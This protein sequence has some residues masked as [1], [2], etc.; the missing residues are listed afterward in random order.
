E[1]SMF[2]T[3]PVYLA[4]IESDP[5]RIR[6]VTARFLLTSRALDTWIARRLA[7]LRTPMLLLLAGRDRI[8]DNDAVRTLLSR[9]PADLTVREWCDA[10]HSLQ[11]DQVDDL[12]GAIA[13][14]VRKV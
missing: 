9:S 13:D 14:F 1:P 8:I 6:H 12:V 7:S 4:Y 11:F 10:T 5:L 2:T 3:T